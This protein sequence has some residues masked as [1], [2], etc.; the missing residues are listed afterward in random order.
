MADRYGINLAGALQG[1]ETIKGSRMRNEAASMDLSTKK[2]L[3][4]ER[5]ERAC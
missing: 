1:A 2:R 5:P 4:A 3:E